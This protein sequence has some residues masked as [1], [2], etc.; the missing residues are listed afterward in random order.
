[1]KSDAVE[2]QKIYEL[3]ASLKFTINAMLSVGGF[4]YRPTLVK[5]V[6]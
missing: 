2:I 5:L 6:I 1:M 4:T 3:K